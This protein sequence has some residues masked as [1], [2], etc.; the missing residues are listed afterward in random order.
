MHIGRSPAQWTE[1][2]ILASPG[3]RRPSPEGTN[4]VRPV[5]PSGPFVKLAGP[6]GVEA[7]RLSR[8]A[9]E[10]GRLAAVTIPAIVRI[11]A[12][13]LGAIGVRVLRRPR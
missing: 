7:R 13:L 11:T 8:V 2:N 5:R 3:T 10:A 9:Q 6:T 12:G 1:P 4:T